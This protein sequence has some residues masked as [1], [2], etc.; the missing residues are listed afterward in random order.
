[1]GTETC[2]DNETERIDAVKTVVITGCA[3]LL[4]SHFSRHLIN[5]GYRVIGIDNLSGGYS[6]YLPPSL[7]EEF[8]FV[9]IDLALPSNAAI[10]DRICSDF[11]PEAV[12]HFAAY[13]AEGLS[14]FIRM[15]NYENNIL[16][17]ANVINA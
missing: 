12:F 1:M 15:F 3:G 6:D 8:Q 14:P 2:G 7:P 16:A 5:K 4:G 11:K 13:A 9:P 10:L 17:S